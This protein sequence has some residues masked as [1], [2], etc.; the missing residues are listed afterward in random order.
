MSMLDEYVGT[1]LEMWSLCLWEVLYMN[2]SN[3]TSDSISYLNVS[4]VT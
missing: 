3:W 4:A 2:C 1:N